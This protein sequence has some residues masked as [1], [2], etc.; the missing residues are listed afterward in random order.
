MDSIASNNGDE[1]DTRSELNEMRFEL[2]ALFV[3]FRVS[4]LKSLRELMHG[5]RDKDKKKVESN[6]EYSN[7]VDATPKPQ[8]PP[9]SPIPP[10]P[11][12][13]Q[14]LSHPAPSDAQNLSMVVRKLFV[15][16]PCPIFGA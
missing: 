8:T 7:Q 16:P 2:K 6:F 15:T 13:P 3:E 10:L 14:P 1:Y 5:E 12:F 9:P 11:Y 4:L